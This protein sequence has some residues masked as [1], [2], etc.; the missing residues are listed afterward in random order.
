MSDGA[1][2]TLGPEESFE[3]DSEALF[4][5]RATYPQ[6]PALCT[7]LWCEWQTGSFVRARCF[8]VAAV[9]TGALQFVL[10]ASD[11]FYRGL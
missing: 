7:F 6:D 4:P 9:P 1:C 10:H 2:L 5:A 3:P 8:V 11:E